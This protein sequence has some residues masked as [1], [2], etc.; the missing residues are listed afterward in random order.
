MISVQF[1]DYFLLGSTDLVVYGATCTSCG[2]SVNRYDD[3][4]SSTYATQTCSDSQYLCM[5]AGK[6]VQKVHEKDQLN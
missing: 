5:N 1:S 2:K 3:T 4:K 6:Y